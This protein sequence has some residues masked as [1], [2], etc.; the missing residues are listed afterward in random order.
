M[1]LGTLCAL[2]VSSA[3][4]QWSDARKTDDGGYYAFTASMRFNNSTLVV[5]SYPN[6]S[7]AP[8]LANVYNVAKAE[9]SALLMETMRLRVDKNPVHRLDAVYEESP[10]GEGGTRVLFMVNLKD[11]LAQEFVRGSR[12]IIDDTN[13]DTDGMKTDE[14]SLSG[15]KGALQS[16]IGKCRS[17]DEWGSSDDDEWAD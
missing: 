7:C 17:Q 2:A 14:F 12:I 13:E 10:N 8:L 11:Q 9:Q 1:A 3:Q 16:V 5:Y 15:S 6:Q 4:A